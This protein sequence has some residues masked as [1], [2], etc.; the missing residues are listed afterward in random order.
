MPDASPDSPQC[1]SVAQTSVRPG[2]TVSSQRSL[3][4]FSPTTREHPAQTSRGRVLARSSRCAPANQERATSLRTGVPAIGR[5]RHARRLM[6]RS[7]LPCRTS[8]HCASSSQDSVHTNTVPYSARREW[9]RVR[10][11]PARSFG[12]VGSLFF[13]AAIGAILRRANEHFDKVVVQSVI[14]LALEVPFELWMVEVAGMQIEIVGVNRNGFVL[15]LD[16]DFYAVGVRARRE[17]QEWVLI[18]L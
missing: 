15:E 3:E 8:Q 1:V 9:G 13:E 18:E 14:E 7:L 12:G 5:R 17:V 16:D 6:C 10:G 11:Y 4:T 2:H